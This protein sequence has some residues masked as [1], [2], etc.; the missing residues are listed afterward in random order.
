M[1][2][3]I[4][5]LGGAQ[6][7]KKTE[8]LLWIQHRMYTRQLTETSGVPPSIDPFSCKAG[9]EYG[10]NKNFD[11]MRECTDGFPGSLV[12]KNPV[13]DGNMNYAAISESGMLLLHVFHG[14]QVCAKDKKSLCTSHPLLRWAVNQTEMLRENLKPRVSTFD[15]TKHMA[16]MLHH[17]MLGVIDL[18]ENI[19]PHGLACY[20]KKSCKARI[21]NFQNIVNKAMNGPLKNATKIQKDLMIQSAAT[22][23][24]L[25]M[26]SFEIYGHVLLSLEKYAE[27]K[28]MFEDS[29]QER[30]G[31]TLSILGLARAHALL[32]NVQQANYFY[33]YLRKQL[34]KA[35]NDNPMVKEAERWSTS[36]G[37]AETLRDQLFLP[38]FL[39]QEEEKSPPYGEPNHY[40]GDFLTPHSVQL[41]NVSSV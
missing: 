33:K 26:P 4:T 36:H 30:M 25:F 3:I 14:V 6:D 22:P 32:G 35:D 41:G 23:T 19:R 8:K 31:R 17:V 34:K 11:F 15:Y 37:Q 27:A 7:W 13:S 2:S 18:A 1:K 21:P 28:A 9:T 16:E 39:K 24:L 12:Q 40:D 29:L 10:K 20:A 5:K 38:Y